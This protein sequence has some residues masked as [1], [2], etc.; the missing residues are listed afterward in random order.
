MGASL[1][2]S[3][4]ISTQW[5]IITALLELDPLSVDL[6]K[7]P[8]QQLIL[9]FENKNSDKLESLFNN[10]VFKYLEVDLNI[11]TSGADYLEGGIG[12]NNILGF[13]GNDEIHGNRDNDLLIGNQGND[14]LYGK[15]GNDKLYGGK[16][17]D[18]LFG[19]AGNDKLVGE[20]GDDKLDGGEGDDRLFGGEGDDRLNGGQG[21]DRLYGGKGDDVINTGTG[22]D[23]ISAGAGDDILGVG[24]Y[25]TIEF[26][27][28]DGIDEIVNLANGTEKNITIKIKENITSDKLRFLKFGNALVIGFVD[29]YQDF[30]ILDQYLNADEKVSIKIEL[31]NGDKVS[32]FPATGFFM[33][34]NKYKQ[35]RQINYYI[36]GATSASIGY[37][38]RGTE[39][40]S[41][42]DGFG[43]QGTRESDIIFGSA[44]NDHI[45]DKGLHG[46]DDYVDARGGDD[47]IEIA[48]GSAEVH[49]GDGNDD[50]L[51]SRGQV[52][53]GRGDDKIKF[54]AAT[55]F[56][57]KGDGKDA[58]TI[59][60]NSRLQFESPIT[61]DGLSFSMD[62]QDLI[63][64]FP[65]EGDQIRLT[66]FVIREGLRLDRVVLAFSDGKEVTTEAI[67]N[68][69]GKTVEKPIANPDSFVTKED[70]SFLID[71]QKLFVND[72]IGENLS[73]LIIE[74]FD[75]KSGYIEERW[76]TIG[77]I[78]WV[79]YPDE[80]FDGI[81]S[82]KYRLSNGF[83]EAEGEVTITVESVNDAPI[84]ERRLNNIRWQA[85]DEFSYRLPANSFYDPDADD[86][87]TLAATLADGEALPDW[88]Q[89]DAEQQR[90]I[91]EPPADFSGDLAI[92]LTATDNAG[93][94][95][96][97]SFT[98]TILPAED[99]SSTTGEETT[100]ELS[101]FAQVK[102]GTNDDEQLLG[103]QE[104]DLIKGLGGNDRVFAFNGDDYLQGGAGDDRLNGGN[105]S[106]KTNDGNDTL[107]GGAGNDVLYGEAG[108]DHLV[109]GIG[110]DH[111]Y[112]GV[113]G[114]VDT[115]D[116]TGGGNDWLFFI[117]GITREQLSYHREDDDLIV[118]VDGDESQQVRVLNHFKGGDFAI[119]YIQPSGGYAIPTSSIERELAAQSGAETETAENTGT[120]NNQSTTTDN[121]ENT[122]DN[123]STTE[124]G[125]NNSQETTG[126]NTGSTD[127]TPIDTQVDS[128]VHLGGHGNN[129]F[130]GTSNA[131]TFLGGAGDDTYVFKLG[132]GQDTIIDTQGKN[133]LVFEGIQFNQVGSNLFKSGND[134]QLSVT[135]T[136]D[137]VII[138]DFFTTANIDTIAFKTGGEIK[139]S[140]LFGI[141]G[142]TMPAA[143]A[144]SQPDI[145]GDNTAN[146][147]TGT[148]AA[149]I[150]KGY[151]DNDTLTGGKG[152]DT[153]IGGR[154][155]DRY[156]FKQGDG[157]DTIIGEGGG[158]DT[159]HFEGF[160]Y[161]DIAQNLFKMGSDLELSKKGTSDKL[162]VK[163][164]FLGGDN[165]VD[166][167]TFS[168]GGQLAG[169][170][171]FQI[172]GIT[173]PNPVQ[174]P[175]YTGL[176]NETDY[177]VVFKGDGSSQAITGSTG[178]DWLEA[179]AGN[180][181]L[182]GGI[183]NDLLLGGQGHD[184]YQFAVGDGQDTIN[185]LTTT[186]DQDTDV[187]SLSGISTDKLWLTQEGDDL[188][189]DVLGSADQ[190]TVQNWF[191]DEGYQLDTIETDNAVLSAEKVDTLVQAMAAFNNYETTDGNLTPEVQTAINPVL[192]AAWQSK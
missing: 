36:Q 141:F 101:D 76:V 27:A 153:L 32:E 137:K 139:A 90:F 68:E 60:N 156:V 94:S 58:L 65:W 43:I 174:S 136:Q 17:H 29:N 12:K 98:L 175:N 105:G 59:G 15:E 40:A 20:E 165:I 177:A 125:T 127:T 30:F 3:I 119:K 157:V 24:K 112:Y 70:S 162:I 69:L 84:I 75:V 5:V 72:F 14:Y 120:D 88:L 56:F 92:K 50:I 142:L 130:T 171:I 63:I 33:D 131:E 91:G 158:T 10:P 128:Y 181:V 66:D 45:S 11:G 82:F 2:N 34:V 9:S 78:P 169:A 81:A 172:F 149:E 123:T 126:E 67:Y 115:I 51:I 147:L 111:Y 47:I 140:Q 135:G 48:G 107:E 93:E 134:L 22:N 108:D 38:L 53:G 28:G 55:A 109:G 52:T 18:N 129:S 179:G 113:N 138:K 73:P 148:D 132:G 4:A 114:G 184:T 95:V 41:R 150:I 146:T 121:S 103:S 31:P 191:A 189:V 173:N 163:D 143:S 21:D 8:I 62:Q 104:A 168:G 6:L 122:T 154:G 7:D 77:Q 83:K 186:P 110:D 166:N 106:G 96:S 86:T 188:K 152:N 64:D 71:P 133:R 80:N 13:S 161:R 19:Q 25:V 23:F 178:A 35:S 54:N 155:N 180:D 159:I 117:N 79:F 190:V 182:A 124:S 145:L 151:D 187:L 26:G 61:A 57:R 176:P 100:P 85:G 170:Q 37:R 42:I 89:F 49:G 164:F 16:G 87:L 97:Q 118:R 39:W 160:S 144:E 102:T 1:D 183:G 44:K 185:N 74:F 167:I 116:N 46:G 99:T 192:A